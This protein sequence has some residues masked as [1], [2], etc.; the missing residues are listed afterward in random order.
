MDPDIDTAIAE[1]IAEQERLEAAVARQR[2]ER[3]ALQAT[4]DSLPSGVAEPELTRATT[5]VPRQKRRGLSRRQVL[6]WAGG[7]IA[8]GA[9]IAGISAGDSALVGSQRAKARSGAELLGMRTRAVLDAK[10][11]SPMVIV[12]PPTGVASV[13]TPNILA[14]LLKAKGGMAVILQWSPTAVYAIDQELPITQG[15]RLTGMGAPMPS[16]TGKYPTLPTLQQVAGVSLQCI[17]ASASYL[18]GLYGPV[19]PGLYPQYNALYNNGVFRSTV[20]GGIEVDHIAFDGQNGGTGSGNTTGHGMVLLSFA[21]NLHDC[22]FLNIANNAMV[23]AEENYNGMSVK[24]ENHENRIQENTVVNPGWH[25]LYVGNATGGATDGYILD[26]N[27]ISPSQQLR[28]SGPQIQPSTGQ[29][30]EAIRM[31]N[32]AGWWMVNNHMTACPGNAWYGNTTGG[33]H[34]LYNTIN[35]FGCNPVHRG[36]YVGFNITTAGQTKLHHGFIIGNLVSAY[37]ASNPFAPAQTANSTNTYE[38]YRLSMQTDVGRKPQPSYQAFVIQSDNVAHQ[39]SQPP[40][41]I[42][43]VTIPVA[44]ALTISLPN[45]ST[46]GVVPGMTV[47]DTLGLIHPGTTVVSVTPGTGTAPDSITISAKASKGSGDT[48][49]FVGPASYAW[50]YVNALANSDVHVTRT[51]ETATGTITPTQLIPKPPSSTVTL[52]DPADFAGGAFIDPTV[53]PAV[54]DIIIATSSTTAAWGPA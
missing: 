31:D 20:D 53:A 50:T 30:Y 11:T 17:A 48:L 54:G 3:A 32:A 36:T 29:Y 1:A 52:V 15:V 10:I 51:N 2:H 46:V 6:H 5:S 40:P 49:S 16:P 24:N 47:T 34:L 4:I 12:P 22:Y 9:V 7:G 38:Y 37:E 28:S 45:G 42:P 18:A 39:G 8:T 33:L 19:N 13:D 41:P 43:N 27:I 35:G 44:N 14:A 26:N 21:A 23:L 25:G